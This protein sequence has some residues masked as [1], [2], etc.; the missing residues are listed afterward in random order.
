MIGVLLVNLGTPAS[1]R[2]GDV[3]RYLAEFLSDPRVIDIHPIARFLLLHLVILRFRPRRSAEAYR[4]IWTDRG[5]PLLLH[6]Q[7]LTQA[8]AGRLGDHFAVALGMRYGAPSIAKGL[9]DL[10]ARGADALVVVPLFPHYS[11]AAWGSAVERVYENLGARWNVPAVRVVAPFHGD[12]GYLDAVAALGRPILEEM[13]PD[14]VLFS[15]HGLPERQVRRSDETGAHCL[16]SAGCCDAL[17][18]AN[19]WCYR[20]Q[21]FATAR[22]VAARLE[23]PADRTTVAFQSRLGRTPWIRPYL[24][25]T[26]RALA[27]QGV[28]RIAV[29][30]PAFVA[31]CL[32]TLEEIR[33]RLAE[34]FR[35]HGGEELRLV[36]ALNATPAWADVVT[37]LVREAATGLS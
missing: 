31:D 32:E 3:R 15:F 7:D 33:L 26:V 29:F 35:A 25:E 5:S 4:K 20:A 28:R 19:R 17:V 23:L 21:C 22:A 27:G 1:T 2:V 34:D 16:A 11:S 10:H 18:P 36:P 6:G 12:A 14:R 13:K 37:R 24:D 9:D 8:V 30:S